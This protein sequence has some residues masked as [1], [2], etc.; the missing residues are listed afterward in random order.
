MARRVVFFWITLALTLL[1]VVQ[2]TSATAESKDDL[3]AATTAENNEDPEFA[4][5]SGGEADSEDA[6]D[7]EW[8]EIEDDDEVG[9]AAASSR[10]ANRAVK[11]LPKVT[12]QNAD[13]ILSSTEYVLLMG[14]ASWCKQSA[15]VMIDF[16]EAATVLAAQGS[17]AVLAK[18]DAVA[19]KVTAN[20]YNIKGY[21]TI[22]FLTNGS[23]E[24]YDAGQTRDDFVNWVLKK[25]GRPATT[26]MTKA[27]AKELQSRD[28]TVVIGLFEKFEGPAYDEF[29]A[30]SKAIV[31]VEFLQTTNAEAAQVFNADFDETAPAI[32]IWKSAPVKFLKFGGELNREEI[33]P[34][35]SLNKFALVTKLHARNAQKVYKSPVNKQVILFASSYDYDSIYPFYLAAAK[36]FKGELFFVWV[37]IEDEDFAKP[38]STMYGIEGS[39][40]TVAGFDNSNGSKYLLE[41]EVTR[42][43][44]KG[45]VINYKEG[46]L[47]VH[48]KSEP[49]PKKN[50]GDVKVVVGKTFDKLVLKNPKD[51]L[52]LVSTSYC[53]DC[54]SVTKSFT[55]LA[56]NYKDLTSIVFAKV[57]ASKNDHPELKVQNYPTIL[58]YRADDKGSPPVEAPTK[59]TL[60]KLVRFVEEHHLGLTSPEQEANISEA[61]VS[62]TDSISTPA[63]EEVQTPRDTEDT[64]APVSDDSGSDP[65]P[66]TSESDSKVESD[67][68]EVDV[69]QAI[70]T[71]SEPAVSNLEVPKATETEDQHD[72]L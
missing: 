52:L 57:D 8:E 51:V 22:L 61:K 48:F 62:D 50:K 26:F 39:E 34:F 35:V 46:R 31:D 3:A 11:A 7:D 47:K 66:T 43:S 64:A 10:S 41:G 25:T 17:S 23:S 29:I 54:E 30:S 53:H 72:E 15:K 5:V 60:K 59:P 2:Q 65:M 56:K 32:A 27:E 40:P 28:A 55:K 37:D 20:R 18:L 6:E 4:A 44:L 45:F 36:Y 24:I 33:V 19:N 67:P 63:D 9:L 21:P 38:M 13:R 42:Q 49:I 58:L 12:D 14:Y 69:Q 16:A 70:D 71:T 68:Q 1:F